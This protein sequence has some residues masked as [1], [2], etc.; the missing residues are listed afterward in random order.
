VLVSPFERPERRQALELGLSAR[1]LRTGCTPA[2]NLF[3]QAAE[4]ILLTERAFEYPLVGDARR[5]DEVEV[6]SVN[7]VSL[8]ERDTR[9]VRR[10]APMYALRHGQDA[11]GPPVYWHA[12]RRPVMRRNEPGSQVFLAFADLSGAVRIPDADVVSAQVT[13]SNAH[14]PSQLPFGLDDQGDF[15]LITGGP[16]DRITCVMSPTRS[17]Q[18]PLGESRLWRLIS[19]LALNH[20]S[21]VDAGA[22]PLRELL[23]LH[24]PG[25]GLAGERQ[26]D[27]LVGVHSA[28]A[29]SRVRSPQ[30]VAFGRG[31]R[32]ELEFDEEQFPGGGMFLFASVLERFLALYASMNSFTQ[33][34][35]RSRQRRRVVREW[36]ARA[37]WRTLL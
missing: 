9:A 25:N 5:R 6:W 31:K 15:E 22:D 13:C 32:V 16:I 30:G 36:P 14:L 23:R 28:P 33:V 34:T 12:V 17:V 21:L 11:E 19:S 4:P 8:I 7:E 29:F 1:S 3:D 18:P 24:N 26:I 27:G 2:I 20:Q 35:A 37:G 10:L